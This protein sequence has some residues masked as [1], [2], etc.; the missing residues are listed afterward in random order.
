MNLGNPAAFTTGL[1][2]ASGARSGNEMRTTTKTTRLLAAP[3]LALVMLGGSLAAAAADAPTAP[4]MPPVGAS[5]AAGHGA[6]ALR[7]RPAPGPAH[8]VDINSAARAE[9]KT[10]PGIG[11]AEADKIIA[12]RPYL[13]KTELVSKN[14]LPT[15]PF[16]TLK[17]LVVAM[18]PKKGGAKAPAPAKAASAS[19]AA[20]AAKPVAHAASGACC[21]IHP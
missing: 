11:D 5:A 9:L 12:N 18:P 15:G 3:A 4:L 17:K 6:G 21:S 19:K 2:F 8:L 16:L 7:K 10:L 14:V 13:T 1:L 20:K